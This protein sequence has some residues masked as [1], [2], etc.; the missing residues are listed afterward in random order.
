MKYLFFGLTI[1]SLAITSIVNGQSMNYW[2]NPVPIA[3]VEDKDKICFAMYTVQDNTLK[4]MVQLYPLADHHSRI[5]Y[6]EIQKNNKWKRIAESKVRENE[7]GLN[8]AKAWNLLFRV[9]NWDMLKDWHYRVVALNGMATYEGIVKHDPAEKDEIVVAAFTGNSRW[10]KVSRKDMVDAVASQNPDLLF[11]SGDQVYHHTHHLAEWLIFG[12]EFGEL[13][14]NRP[15]VSIP[16]DHDVGQGNLWGASGKQS[17]VS[18]GSDGGYIQSPQYVREVEF[19]QTSNLPDGYDPTP[20]QRDIGVYYTSLNIGGVDFA[21][22]EDRK[23]KQGPLEVFPEV[24]G[25]GRPDHP[26]N[27]HPDA[28]DAPDAVL[29]G[30]R[31]LEFLENWGMNWQA[32]QMK[33]VLSQTIFCQ[34]HTMQTMDLDV[35]GWPQSGRNRALRT[36][37]KSF[38]FMLAGDQHLATVIHHGIDEF[39]DAGYSFC[40][41]SIV[42][43]YPR[44]WRPQQNAERII[45]GPLDGLGDYFDGLGNRITMYSHADP[46]AFEPPIESMSRWVKS[47][48]GYGIVRFNKSN[49]TIKMECWPRGTEV[50]KPDAKQYPGWPITISQMDNYGKKAFGF[51]PKLKINGQ[52]DPVVQVINEDSKEVVYTIRIKGNIFQPKVFVR[53]KHTVK[54]GEGNAIKTLMGLEPAEKDKQA[55]IIVNFN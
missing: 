51:L 7:Y 43:H 12:S 28:L 44:Y 26:K 41:P 16:D 10:D 38:A 55:S 27:I 49:R 30:K 46:K 35:N 18:G 8:D 1:L 23:F 39:G 9:E 31:Q 33:C 29:L 24:L 47:A 20:V 42:N 13:T 3:D 40:M 2:S 53:G 17:T 48:T 11:F 25:K 52:P 14:R 45:N 36:I 54:V 6:L 21:I 5:V 34:G 32:V 15:A 50:T 19:A 22:I 37:R 4:M